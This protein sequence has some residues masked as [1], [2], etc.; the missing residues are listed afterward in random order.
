MLRFFAAC[1]STESRS[2]SSDSQSVGRTLVIGCG[3]ETSPPTAHTRVETSQ[4]RHGDIE[5]KYKSAAR[6]GAQGLPLSWETLEMI[7]GRL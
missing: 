7:H 6:S 5:V 3:L 2:A 1:A 4:W